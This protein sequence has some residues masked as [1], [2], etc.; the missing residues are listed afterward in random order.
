MSNQVVEPVAIPTSH[1]AF[2]GHPIGLST[3]FF[4][5]MWERASY[6]GMRALLI[7]YMTDTVRGGLGMDIQTGSAIY[8]LYTFGVYA[9]ALPG[10]WIADRLVGQRRAVLQGAVLIALGHY[11][12]ALPY[13]VA[14]TE[15]WSFYLGLFLVV[16]GTGLL[17]P[18]V[19]AIVGDLY[20][21]DEPARRDAGFSIF[22]MGIN[23]GAVIGPFFCSLLGE[24]VNWHLGFSVAG[25]GMTF[26]LL[27]YALGARHLR[28]A[29]ELKED[30]ADPGRLAD[31][32]R[33]LAFAL[34]LVIILAGSVIGLSR[35]GIL[36]LT[37]VGFAQW[38][39]GI[40]VVLALFYFAWVIGF[41]CRDQTERRRVGLCAIL[42]IGAAMFWSGFEQAGSSFN[43]F[44]Q[45]STD[46]VY[47]G[48]ETPAGWFQLINPMFIVM[49]APVMGILW[50]KLNERNPSIPAK[51]GY[52]L[53]LLGAGF[54]VLA[55]GA[56]YIPNG[57]SA[58]P[59]V[60][61]TPAWLLAT[62]FFHTVG[63]L[64]LSP[65]GLS[66]ITKLSPKRL[67]GQMMGTWF[68]GAALG[69][70]IAGLVAGYLEA[71][72][73]VQ[74]FTAVAGIAAGCGLL[75]LV[76]ARPLN[77]LAAGVK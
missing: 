41:V 15:Y 58:D 18:N 53:V 35:A 72:P 24:K 13:F 74:L 76:L 2:F 46:R 38:T 27:Q 11:S 73:T 40:I 56:N 62:Y 39:G 59:G 25:I 23:I 60:G 67:V 12:L 32:R 44:A 8:G 20:A 33:K 28:G 19:S 7:L 51:F 31:A 5:E 52:G 43:L 37:L 30:S 66:S 57:A 77:W 47:L 1:R 50:V 9:L 16:I 54:F 68:M 49:L 71:L 65:I 17:K 10:G 45:D 14:G 21:D 36:P 63:E 61:I 26:G 6:Y 64:C 29:G 3:L 55:W 4:T 75:F 22:Y 70:L 42:F 69:N 48:W 34:G